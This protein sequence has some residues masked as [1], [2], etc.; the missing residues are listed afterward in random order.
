MYSGGR[1]IASLSARDLQGFLEG[2]K[3]VAAKKKGT[4][5]LQESIDQLA[6]VQLLSISQI[7]SIISPIEAQLVQQLDQTRMLMHTQLTSR[8][9]IVSWRHLNLCSNFQIRRL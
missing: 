6:E 3:Q 4:S 7:S 1:T 2:S 8:L 5:A 9:F